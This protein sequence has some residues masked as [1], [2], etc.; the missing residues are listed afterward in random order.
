VAEPARSIAPRSTPTDKGIPTLATELWELV[1]G[2][3]KQE[4]LEPVKGLGRFVGYGVFGAVF[5]ATGFVLLSVALLR[6]LQIETGDHL[7]GNLSWVPYVLTMLAVV[8]VAGLAA[9]RI[10]AARRKKGGR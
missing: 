6:A 10:T 8:G 5:I 1:V 3:L 2:Y 4:T 9:T 7:T